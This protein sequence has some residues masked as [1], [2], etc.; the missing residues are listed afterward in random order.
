[1]NPDMTNETAFDATFQAEI[2]AD[3]WRALCHL[4][5]KEGET[6]LVSNEDPFGPIVTRYVHWDERER[7]LAL[8]A[9]RDNRVAVAG[10]GGQFRERCLTCFTPFRPQCLRF[11]LA[12][13]VICPDCAVAPPTT[14][15][16]GL[17]RRCDALRGELEDLEWVLYGLGDS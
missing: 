11:T 4:A 1:M 2:D 5:G 13:R 9:E 17:R 3:E 6:T 10:A 7:L 8:A 12:E 16:D 14:L 15:A